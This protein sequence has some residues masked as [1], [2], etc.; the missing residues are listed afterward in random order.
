MRLSVAPLRYGAGFKGKIGTSLAH[1]LPAVA[2]PIAM[3]GTG[4]APGEGVLVGEDAAAFAEAVIRLHGEAADWATLS[5]T[6][7]AA[8]EALFSPDAALD[9]YRA[10]LARLGLPAL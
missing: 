6:G 8:C 9:I 7:L 4:L 10:M 3:E 2:T 1:G 5:A